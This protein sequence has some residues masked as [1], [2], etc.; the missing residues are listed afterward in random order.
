MAS[1]KR[2]AYWTEV[3]SLIE[4][5]PKAAEVADSFGWLPLHHAA[6][7][8]GV[9][10]R[11]LQAL[12]SAYPAGI[13]CVTKEQ[14]CNFAPEHVLWFQ[15][16]LLFSAVQIAVVVAVVAAV[17]FVEHTSSPLTAGAIVFGVASL[18]IGILPY[19]SV[20][21]WRYPLPSWLHWLRRWDDSACDVKPQLAV[22]L[23]LARPAALHLL[24]SCAPHT[25]IGTGVLHS[26]VACDALHDSILAD[27]L[28]LQRPY[29]EG[30]TLFEHMMHVGDKDARPL[31]LQ[32]HC[33]FRVPL[34]EADVDERTSWIGDAYSQS[35]LETQPSSYALDAPPVCYRC[36]GKVVELGAGGF[37]AVNLHGREGGP[38]IA[39]KSARTA[40]RLVRRPLES[41]IALQQ[42]FVILQTLAS[43]PRIVQLLGMSFLNGVTVHLRMP[44]APGGDL[45][46]AMQ[47]SDWK[48]CTRWRARG[49]RLACDAAEGLAFLAAHVVDGVPVPIWHHDLKPANILL[50]ACPFLPECR[51]QLTD[52]GISAVERRDAGDQSFT[53]GGW[54]APEVYAQTGF[55]CV[56]ANRDTWSLGMLMYVLIIAGGNPANVAFGPDT[57]RLPCVR[58]GDCKWLRPDASGSEMC[59]CECG[60]ADLCTVAA[61]ALLDEAC[62]FD[63]ARRPSVKQMCERML[64]CEP[65][66]AALEQVAEPASP[67]AGAH[68]GSW[69]V[70]LGAPDMLE[71]TTLVRAPPGMRGVDS[72][73]T[74]TEELFAATV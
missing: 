38:A 32:L 5:N 26:R 55:A 31:I 4:K 53:G 21:V 16:V 34:P 74:G 24:I 35:S 37:G 27:R 1:V 43:H 42:D 49:W 7:L 13:Q 51:A 23:A 2:A 56:D 52:F 66:L 25:A 41:L 10:I 69:V 68:N 59:C 45:H 15:H 18:C 20:I 71:R 28:L 73:R 61:L 36:T 14:L 50:T 72:S 6:S 64:R 3:V 40:R 44:F 70:Q 47:D 48:H 22:Q 17:V 60:A 11:V 9:P 12:L 19:Y 29:V 8:N 63:T 58:C 39:V 46:T 30:R 54:A 67:A 33:L 57:K 65:A 62:T